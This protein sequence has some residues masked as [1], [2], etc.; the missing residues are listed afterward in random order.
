[1]NLLEVSFHRDPALRGNE[2]LPVG[3]VDEPGWYREV[4]ALAPVF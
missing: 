2:G 3:L 4:Q 1:M